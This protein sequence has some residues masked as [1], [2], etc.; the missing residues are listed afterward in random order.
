MGAESKTVNI[1]VVTGRVYVGGGEYKVGSVINELLSILGSK[2]LPFQRQ[3]RKATAEVV[4]KINHNR[5]NEKRHIVSQYLE[6]SSRIE[7]AYL[8]IDSMVAFGKDT[9]LS[10]LNGLY[11]EGLNRFGIDCLCQD[12]DIERVR[13][14]ADALIVFIIERLRDLVMDS[15]RPPEFMEFVEIGVNVVVAHAFIEC[16]VMENP[17]IVTFS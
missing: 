16:I 3:N 14:N 8:E 7:E 17:E 12:V 4:K 11:V 15:A 6:Y 1:G 10:N 5:L 2:R 9:I 13:E